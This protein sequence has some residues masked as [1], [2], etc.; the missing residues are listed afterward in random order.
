M[1][2]LLLSTPLLFRHRC[3]GDRLTQLLQSK[4]TPKQ[5]YAVRATPK[6]SPK[7]A[8]WWTQFNNPF[9]SSRCRFEIF[10]LSIVPYFP[11]FSP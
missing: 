1:S 4:W 11:Y 9:S 8:P 5:G 10:L 2:R 7:L 3:P 6:T